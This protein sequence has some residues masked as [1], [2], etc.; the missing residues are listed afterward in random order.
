MSLFIKVMFLFV[1]SEISYSGTIYLSK[2]IDE[3][4][5]SKIDYELFSDETKGLNFSSHTIGY[6]DTVWEKRK[7]KYNI[8][9]GLEFLHAK[10]SRGDFNFVSFFTMFNYNFSKKFYS[11]VYA[12]IDFF[13]HDFILN[14]EEVYKPDAKGGPMYGLGFSYIL[15]KKFPVSLNYKI[16]TSSIVQNDYWVDEYYRRASFSVG[17]KF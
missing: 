1:F 2:S 12:G 17:Y 6:Y 5:S 14:N 3:L 13:N 7:I 8:N 15:N 4:S 10:Q 16:Y 9:L 11:T